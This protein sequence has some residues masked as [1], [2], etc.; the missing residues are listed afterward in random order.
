[1]K[2]VKSKRLIIMGILFFFFL[3]FSCAKY[4]A[5]PEKTDSNSPRIQF[6][7]EIYNFGI[8]G[9]EREITHDFVFKNVGSSPL[10]IE[11]LKTSCGCMAVLS[12]GDTIAPGETGIIHA[13]FKTQRYEGKQ[14]KFI[15]VESNDPEK[16]KIEL[17]MQ[18]FIKTDIAIDPQ[19]LHFGNVSKGKTISKKVRVFDLNKGELQL[20]RIQFNENYFNIKADRFK[21]ENN[22]G[23]ELEITLKP[24]ISGGSFSEVITLHTNLEKRPRIDIPIW[25]NIQ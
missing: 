13:T 6:E 9:Q 23:F 19:G 24:E 7:R 3:I 25:G 22:R 5:Q 8:A 2:S 1:M 20:K 17:V 4:T 15:Y 12:S 16:P 10:Q 21:G 18:G 11:S 14:K